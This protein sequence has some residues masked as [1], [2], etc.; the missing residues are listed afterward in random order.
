MRLHPV[1]ARTG[2]LWVRLG[3]STFVQRPLALGGLF[4]LFMGALSVASMVPLLGT[5]LALVLL[6]AA[7][8]GLMAATQQAS[9][10]R[11]P[12]PLVLATAFR[13]GKNRLRSMAHLGLL[14]AVGFLGVMA[15]TALVDGGGFARFYL[16]GQTVPVETLKTPAFQAAMWVAMLLYMP[17]AMLFWHAPALVHWH[18]VSP[19]KSLFFS[20]LA[21]W[22]NK[23]A[24]LVF[25]LGWM[26]LFVGTSLVLG[27][28]SALV[29]GP[30]VFGWVM[31]PAALVMASMLFT[32]FYFTFRD[33]FD[34][35][36]E[37][38]TQDTAPR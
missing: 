31:L 4:L 30:Q 22:R 3:V 13:A 2:L 32:S 29:G 7:T 23:A 36:G 19:V 5:V 14:Y 16:G 10:G 8:L 12:T 1:P 11:F 17:L 20:W 26:G 38:D 24:L 27:L 25:G 34:T 28:V 21:C 33:S 35:Q 37:A 15:L 6:P 9:Q 18:G